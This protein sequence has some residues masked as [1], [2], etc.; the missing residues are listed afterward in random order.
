[1]EGLREAPVLHLKVRRG[2]ELCMTA[3]QARDLREQLDCALEDAGS[4]ADALTRA[5]IAGTVD[6]GANG[7]ARPAP[8]RMGNAPPPY[9]PARERIVERPVLPPNLFYVGVAGRD[10]TVGGVTDLGE[11]H[12]VHVAAPVHAGDLLMF[13]AATYTVR[14]AH[15]LT[16]GT[17][18]IATALAGGTVT[19]EVTDGVRHAP[20]RGFEEVLPQLSPD[21]Q[22]VDLPG[23][24]F[25]FAPNDTNVLTVNGYRYEFTELTLRRDGGETT[26][27]LDAEHPPVR[28]GATLA[29]VDE[30]G[31]GWSAEVV[32]VMEE[33][34]S[35]VEGH[36]A[37]VNFSRQRPRRAD[38]GWLREL[39][40]R[41]EGPPDR[42]QAQA[43]ASTA[44]LWRAVRRENA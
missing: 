39:L 25:N 23:P 8:R 3:E 38:A 29:F 41:L 11:L 2:P 16:D 13:D 21:V 9:R 42:W 31:E 1:M 19:A 44:R 37:R 22:I 4:E 26:L 28:P 27:V 12:D 7:V 40:D 34:W 17:A 24:A 10:L 18:Q 15:R 6:L 32:Q 20:L 14:P 5:L 35:N 33:R 30:R 43:I 36:R